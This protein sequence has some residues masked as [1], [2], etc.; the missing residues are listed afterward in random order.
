MILGNQAIVARRAHVAEVARASGLDADSAAAWVSIGQWNQRDARC[1]RPWLNTRDQVLLPATFEALQPADYESPTY[2]LVAYLS[3]RAVESYES[4]VPALAQRVFDEGGRNFRF[5]EQGTDAGFAYTRGEVGVLAFRGTILWNLHQWVATNF[6]MARVGTPPR[7]SGFKRAWHRLRP[8]VKDWLQDNV[9]PGGPLILC[10]H[11][12]GGAIALLA[13]DELCAGN[14]LRAVVTFGAPRVGAIEFRD[15]YLDR[16]AAPAGHPAAVRRLAQVTRR[17]THVDD[18]VS[19]VPPP[20]FFRHIGPEWRLDEKGEIQEGRSRSIN[21]RIVDAM[22]RSA[23]WFYRQRERCLEELGWQTN[24]LPAPWRPGMAIEAPPKS[25]LERLARDI[26]ARFRQ[27][28]LLQAYALQIGLAAVGTVAALYSGSA[29]V[30]ASFDLWSHRS[31]LYSNGLLRHYGWVDYG[32]APGSHDM[33][34][35]AQAYVADALQQII[36]RRK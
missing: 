35:K 6:R 16:P 26:G 33:Q 7:H 29:M 36:E 19:R 3:R 32:L 25:A 15:A 23:G 8:Q 31:H 13:A 1:R 9:A 24:E 5:F 17:I 28:P 20:P 22:D 4:D 14:E 30:L 10:G 34:L 12:L 2:D 21:A 27:F 11:S 18:L